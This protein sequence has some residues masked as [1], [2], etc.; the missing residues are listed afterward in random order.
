[1]ALEPNIPGANQPD[2]LLASI[3]AKAA[4]R[5]DAPAPALSSSKPLQIFLLVA[6]V[7]TGAAYV[8]NEVTEFKTQDA[9]TQRP[10]K[11]RR[12]VADQSKFLT[13]T[14]LGHQ[15]EAKKQYED[16]VL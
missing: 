10:T 5:T 4:A 12:L 9:K 7:I 1:M 16:A 14:D 11:L 3:R 8:V 6:M 15:S 13:E 2:P